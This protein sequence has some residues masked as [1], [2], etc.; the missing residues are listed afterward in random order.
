MKKLGYVRARHGRVLRRHY[1]H[2]SYKR[3]PT[4]KATLQQ[5]LY[6]VNMSRGSPLTVCG[7][8]ILDGSTAISPRRTAGDFGTGVGGEA[9]RMSA[10][11][12]HEMEI[13]I[14]RG[15]R[16][17]SREGTHSALMAR[18]IAGARAEAMA[19]YAVDGK[20]EW[21]TNSKHSGYIRDAQARV[22]AANVTLED[23][24]DSVCTRFISDTT[25]L[26]WFSFTPS[27]EYL[28]PRYYVLSHFLK[29]DRRI[30]VRLS[31]SSSVAQS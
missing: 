18:K 27:I 8:Q 22:S 10:R 23:S 26:T 5:Y 30:R 12:L 6:V 21:N 1:S 19:G 3:S 7:Y 17:Q 28:T 20:H 31:I 11:G 9:W 29:H 15:L 24:L 16:G 4:T 25:K 14:R 13:A 2:H